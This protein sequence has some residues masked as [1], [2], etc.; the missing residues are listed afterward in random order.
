MG[1]LPSLKARTSPRITVTRTGVLVVTNYSKC[2]AWSARGWRAIGPSA[3]R[4][5]GR[6]GTS[7]CLVHTLLTAKTLS[8]FSTPE[9]IA[10]RI[11]V[12]NSKLIGNVASLGMVHEENRTVG[13]SPTGADMGWTVGL[14]L[15]RQSAR[16]RRYGNGGNTASPTLR[17]YQLVAEPYVEG[18]SVKVKFKTGLVIMLY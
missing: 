7:P 18:N 3:E 8:G 11:V 1:F 13:V 9:D 4:A 5:E 17:Q 6:R 12:K 14:L 10:S 16:R 15:P 2:A